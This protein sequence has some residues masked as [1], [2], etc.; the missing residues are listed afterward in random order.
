MYSSMTTSAIGV[1][2]S[3]DPS[4]DLDLTGAFCQAEGRLHLDRELLELDFHWIEGHDAGV[5][6]LR[7]RGNGSTGAQ[8]DLF[9]CVA[10]L[11]ALDGP[12]AG[13]M[14]EVA[15][16]EQRL[17]DEGIGRILDM[18]SADAAGPDQLRRIGP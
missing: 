3:H 17:E 1:S 2:R 13:V 15:G 12:F 5:A 7:E 9:F 14:R 18:L 16:P 10:E 8:V 6:L 4:D 11:A